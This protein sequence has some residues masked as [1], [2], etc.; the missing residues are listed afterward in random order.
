[1]IDKIYMIIIGKDA[2]FSKEIGKDYQYEFTVTPTIEE[3]GQPVPDNKMYWKFFELKRF[4]KLCNNET[5][6]IEQSSPKYHVDKWLR[7]LLE[8]GKKNEELISDNTPE[9]IK[10][11][12][13]VMETAKMT[14]Q[15]YLRYQDE[16]VHEYF[17]RL[18]HE[19]SIRKSEEAERKAEEAIKKAQSEGLAEGIVKG[20]AKGLVSKLQSLLK[21]TEDPKSLAEETGFSQ[22]Q[23]QELIADRERLPQNALQ[24]LGF[25]H[26]LLAVQG[27]EDIQIS[28][29]TD[30]L[31]ESSLM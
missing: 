22:E 1:M 14:P 27:S 30:V 8:C 18:E 31:T 9:I 19:S 5:I 16:K 3:L 21:F 24:M 23:I 7:F 28:G 20:E 4:E 13:K 6:G 10:E 29:D 25:D 26:D 11:A 17:E 12:Y 15:E 2:I